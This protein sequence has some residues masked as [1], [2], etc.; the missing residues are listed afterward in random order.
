MSNDSDNLVLEHLK[1]IQIQLAN[2]NHEMKELRQDV[3]NTHSQIVSC[4]RD[5]LSLEENQASSAL[6]IDRFSDNLSLINTRLDIRT[7]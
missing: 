6:R 7:E 3:R 4:R 1:R 2:L 5:V